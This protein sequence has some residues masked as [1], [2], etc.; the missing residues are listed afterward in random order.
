GVFFEPLRNQLART[1]YVDAFETD[2]AR[3]AI[4]VRQQEMRLDVVHPVELVCRN[5]G[6]VVAK[7]GMEL[8]DTVPEGFDQSR[9][10]GVEL[11]LIEAEDERSIVGGQLAKPPQSIE[12]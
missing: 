2:F 11:G 9:I 12:T 7:F 8:I 6:E 1:A 3:E 5:D 10:A 4:P